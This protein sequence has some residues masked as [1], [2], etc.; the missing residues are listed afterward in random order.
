MRGFG[1]TALLLAAS[2][3]AFSQNQLP[4]TNCTT[5]TT[6]LICVLPNLYGVNGLTLDPTILAENGQHH[7]PHFNGTFQQL[8]SSMGSALGSELAN[9]P[10]A[11]PAS[12][13]RYSFESG[14][15]LP[16]K[17]QQS[18]GPVFAE[19]AETMGKG[20]FYFAV[21]YQYFDFTSLNGVSL[22]DIPAVFTHDDPGA[23]FRNDFITT[24][25]SVHLFVDQT[26]AFATYGLTPKVDVSVAIPLLHVRVSGNAYAW[27][28]WTTDASSNGGVQVH[29]FPGGMQTANYPAG[30]NTPGAGNTTG[31]GDV[32]IRVKRT[33]WRRENFALAL[34]TDLRTP[35]GDPENFLGSGTFGLKPFVIASVRAGKVSPHLNLGYQINGSSLLAGNFL[36]YNAGGCED[37]GCFPNPNLPRKA[38]LPNNLTYAIGADVG[39]TRKLTFAFD[40]LGQRVYGSNILTPAPAYVSTVPECACSTVPAASSY[41]QSVVSIGNFNVLRGSAGFKAQIAKDLLLTVNALLPLNDDGL[42]SKV[43]PMVGLSYTH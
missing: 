15:G 30:G 42:K 29:Q 10:L 34:A 31:I 11:S 9:L 4:Q 7:L 35:T 14:T 25:N 39:A 27:L 1:A 17:V 19:R 3:L 26:T 5:R 12:G 18:F 22:K 16:S 38:H 43:V 6:Q 41:P 8:F 37:L 28:H 24:R 20:M 21:T 13:F 33:M 23:G 40:L 2:A 32:T 36:G